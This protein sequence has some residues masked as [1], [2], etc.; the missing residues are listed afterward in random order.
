MASS[1]PNDPI[2][3][4]VLGGLMRNRVPGYHFAGNFLQVSFERM[5]PADCLTTIDVGPHCADPSGQAAAGALCLLADMALASGV[6]AAIPQHV[7]LA[8]VNMQLQFT[9]APAVDRLEAHSGFE[10]MVQGVAGKQSI[11]R[12]TILGGGRPVCFGSGTFM[13]L[14]MPAGAT[15]PPMRPVDPQA[16]VDLPDPASELQAH[17]A[18]IY[19]RARRMLALARRGGAPFIERF[20][21]LRTRKTTTGAS[22]SLEAGQQVGNRVGHVQGG[23][24]AGLVT[25]TARAAL[26]Q[27]WTLSSMALTFLSPGH[28][29]RVSARARVVHQ[30]RSTAVVQVEVFNQDRRRVMQGLTTHT[31]G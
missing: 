2:L 16:P 28:A 4:R 22:G 3:R 13:V 7:R 19:L 15:V 10:G 11:S 1:L 5:T 17:E 30:G 24:L 29:P 12:V 9:G 31:A 14:P 23:I 26:P 18:Q 27:N 25:N 6:R 21:G 8:T 20:W